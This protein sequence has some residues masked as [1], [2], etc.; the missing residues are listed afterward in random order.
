MAIGPALLSAI[1]IEESLAKYPCIVIDPQI[2]EPRI[3]YYID[4]HWPGDERMI[5]Y[6]LISP[7]VY[8]MINY[9]EYFW[10]V[11]SYDI[12]QGRDFCDDT[13]SRVSLIQTTI[14]RYKF[15]IIDHKE[16]IE[17]QLNNP[18]IKPEVKA[19][20][21]WLADYHNFYF[22]RALDGLVDELEEFLI[23]K[24]IEFTFQYYKDPEFYF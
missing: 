5:K 3:K 1:E 6:L 17:D 15:W 14:N 16:K 24:E 8:W 11:I 22:K 4:N 12:D 20:F 21:L 13:N 23:S 10:D 18:S 19:K 9:F 7:D 2:L